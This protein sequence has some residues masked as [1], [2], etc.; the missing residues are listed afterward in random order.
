L[1]LAVIDTYHVEEVS[2]GS[3]GVEHLRSDY[4]PVIVCLHPVLSVKL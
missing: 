3:T 4:R 2:Q 1:R